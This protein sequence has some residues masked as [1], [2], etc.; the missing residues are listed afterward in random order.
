MSF[1]EFSYPQVLTDLSLSWTETELFPDVAPVPLDEAFTR[2]MAEAVTLA[3]AVNTEKAKSEFIIA[4]I[5]LELRRRS[6]RKFGL[7][8]GVELRVDSSRGLNGVCDFL[9]TRDTRQTAVVAPLI[10]V[11][12]AK[13]D[14]LRVGL[15][16]CV[17]TAYASHLYNRQTDG[18]PEPVYGVV[19][20][21]S[22]WKFLRLDDQHLT[23]DLAEFYVDDLP[24]LFG[25]LQQIAP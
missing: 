21:G 2:Q 17:A 20:T 4:P 12:E 9:L 1:Q 22:A 11:V 15:G 6:A 7:F 8:S 18:P 25:V 13:N 3:L 10:A 19:T 16:Q 5:L 14:N 24:R 23:L